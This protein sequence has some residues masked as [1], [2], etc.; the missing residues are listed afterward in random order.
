MSSDGSIKWRGSEEG[1]G[2]LLLVGATLLVTNG[3]TGAIKLFATDTE[4]CTELA[5]FP[6]LN[7]KTWNTPALAGDQLF[8]R[9]QYE[10]RV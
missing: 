8:V 4:E 7:E 2:Q 10:I 3:D 6:L 1:P 5:H 9:N